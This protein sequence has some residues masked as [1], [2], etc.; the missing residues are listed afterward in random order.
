[1]PGQRLR[2]DMRVVPVPDPRREDIV[3]RQ[4][5]G[6]LGRQAELRIKS[7]VARAGGG[8]SHRPRQREGRRLGQ[9]LVEVRDLELRPARGPHR[10]H[11]R[12]LP[13]GAPRDRLVPPHQPDGTPVRVN[14]VN[15]ERQRLPA[16]RR[17]RVIGDSNA[18]P[19]GPPDAPAATSSSAPP[20][21]SA[22]KGPGRAVVFPAKPNSSRLARP[23]QANI[24]EK[25]IGM[26]RLRRRKGPKPKRPNP[27][28]SG[29]NA[30]A[31]SSL[32]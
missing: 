31:R 30:V 19:P 7:R 27:G 20:E 25:F 6:H 4:S 16:D 8:D 29:A 15:R 9:G 10:P 22:M 28:A 2:R 13:G 1:M 17:R 23:K 3:L 26:P 32:P 14:H 21:R 11:T 5:R 24:R 18:E 12:Q